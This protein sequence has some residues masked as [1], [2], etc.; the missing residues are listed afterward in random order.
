MT[1]DKTQFTMVIAAAE[2]KSA[3][4]LLIS[5]EAISLSVSHSTTAGRQLHSPGDDNYIAPS[6]TG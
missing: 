5:N 3:R 1:A 6:V 2:V 4:K